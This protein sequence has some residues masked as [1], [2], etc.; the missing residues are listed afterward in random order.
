[1]LRSVQFVRSVNLLAF[2]KDLCS[3][4]K[5]Y[6]ISDTWIFFSTL[7]CSRRGAVVLRSVQFA[8]S[9]NL[10]TL[11][12]DLCSER[13]LFIISVNCISLATL[14]IFLSAF[15]CS[16]KGAVVL[17]SVQFVRSVNLLAFRKDLC[18][19]RKLYMISDT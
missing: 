12:K 3:E 2:R 7:Y 15:Y 18:S 8:R 1:M 6:I 9:V 16:K 10:F 4:R 13:K 19:E 14:R 17:R 11:R 5:L